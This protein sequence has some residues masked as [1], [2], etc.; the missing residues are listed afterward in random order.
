MNA[1]L[2]P[3]VFLV[4]VAKQGQLALRAG[5]LP[6]ERKVPIL[7]SIALSQLSINH[8]PPFTKHQETY[9]RIMPSAVRNITSIGIRHV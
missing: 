7:I 6:R 1:R 5:D 2:W 3:D 4:V 9:V 8:E